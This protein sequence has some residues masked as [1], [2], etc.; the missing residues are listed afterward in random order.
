PALSAKP[1]AGVAPAA[2]AGADPHA[3]Q[4]TPRAEIRL[5]AAAADP[6]A[7]PEADPPRAPEPVAAPAAAPA[8]GRRIDVPA[9]PRH[10][11]RPAS[12]RSK[13]QASTAATPTLPT[14]PPR[15]GEAIDA[16]APRR[17]TN[18]VLIIR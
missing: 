8:V 14:A 17:G 12:R 7:P 9:N 10:R 1:A 6:P 15:S 4:E 13:R 11:E 5:P 3:P 18:D 2:S 16:P